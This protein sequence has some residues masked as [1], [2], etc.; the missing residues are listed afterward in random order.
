MIRQLGIPAHLVLI[1]TRS[2]G[3]VQLDIPM[4]QFNHCIVTAEVEGQRYWMDPTADTCNFGYIPQGIQDRN[5][6]VMFDEQARFIK[7]PLLPPDRS[8]TIKKVE[9]TL[10]PDGSIKGDSR[11][12][13]TGADSMYYRRMRFTK[14]IK[15]RHHLERIVNRAYPGGKLLGYEFSDLDDLNIPVSLQ[16]EY[17]GPSFLKKAGNLGIIPPPGVGMGAGSVSLKERTYPISFSGLWHEENHI[18]ITLPDNYS[19][20]YLPEEVRLDCLPYYTYHLKFDSRDGKITYTEKTEL[21]EREIPVAEYAR[22]KKFRET[23]A[24]ETDK[25]IIL[26]EKP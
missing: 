20:Y 3:K 16:M 18:T 5:A 2:S 13:T 10:A 17:S 12:S 14:P 6:L 8:T 4:L 25:F 26:K 9:L 19:V 15:R 1:A 22:Y 11:T 7:T 23:I 21:R 24:R